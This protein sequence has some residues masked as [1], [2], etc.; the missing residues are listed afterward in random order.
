MDV[1]VLCVIIVLG[2]P[3]L[4]FLIILGT[5]CIVKRIK[6]SRERIRLQS[7]CYHGNMQNDNGNHYFLMDN[8]SKCFIVRLP[9]ENY[10]S[11]GLAVK[12]MQV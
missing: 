3:A 8:D 4:F 9:L 2:F 6:Q 12:D 11:Y 7:H 10:I 5:A 1:T